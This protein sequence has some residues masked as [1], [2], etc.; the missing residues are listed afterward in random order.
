MGGWRAKIGVLIPSVN[1]VLEPD[2][3]RMVPRGV[4]VHVSRLARSSALRDD[5]Q[6][7]YRMNQ[8]IER[9]ADEIAS[10]DVNV[11]LYGCTGGS[12]LEGLGYDQQIIERI[13]EETGIE[14][15]T[16]ATAVVRALRHLAI[17]RLVVATPY[18]DDLNSMERKFLEQSGFEVLNLEGLSLST[19]YASW[20]AE[21]TYSFARDLATA[22]GLELDGIFVSCTNFPAIKV[23]E[24]LEED[25]GVS[26]VTSNQASLWDCLRI[27]G[28]RSRIRGYGHL[29][30]SI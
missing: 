7:V 2:F 1:T 27:V 17:A 19:D 21:R 12:L 16:T 6:D 3:Y 26:V 30:E 5:L 9:A 10:A 14:A 28:V 15:T 24:A 11:I 22:V 18:S 23:I 29:L 4:T 13:E 25:L 8:Q 20:P